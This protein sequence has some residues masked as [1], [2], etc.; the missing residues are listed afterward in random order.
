M[1]RLNTAYSMY[2]RYKH[3]EPEELTTRRYA[4]RVA[5]KELCCRYSGESQ[6]AVGEH[7]G[8]RGNGSVAKQRQRLVELLDA[9]DGLKRKLKR[10]ERAVT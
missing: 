5:K 6:R 4:A 8:Y 3:S 10:V 7:F 9:T 2:H 1:Q